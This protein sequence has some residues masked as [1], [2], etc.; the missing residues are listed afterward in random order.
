MEGVMVHLKM[1]ECVWNVM[2][3]AQKPDFI[4]RWNGWVHLH[5]R[6]CQFRRLLAAEVCTS[7]LLLLDV[8]RSE[9]V[10]EYWLPTPVVSFPF[11]FPPVRHSNSNST[12]IWQARRKQRNCHSEQTVSEPFRTQNF[13]YTAMS[14][15]HMRPSVNNVTPNL[16]SGK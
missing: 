14:T 4:F 5:R 9:V 3:H 8:P 10:W 16:I 13:V 11:I 7:A 1:V 6:G 2:A 15:I 12:C